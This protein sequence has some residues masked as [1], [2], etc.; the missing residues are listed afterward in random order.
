MNTMAA[1]SFVNGLAT[2]AIMM[3][4][5]PVIASELRE[6]KSP[7]ALLIASDGRPSS[8]FGHSLAV[9]GSTLIAGAPL[10]ETDSDWQRGSAYVFVEV[11]NSWAEQAILIAEDGLPNDLFGWSVAISGKIAAVGAPNSVEY[12]G[13]VYVFERNGGTWTQRAKLVA[14]D[15]RRDQVFGRSVAVSGDTILVGSPYWG[16]GI[17]IEAGAAYVFVREGESWLQQ[18]RLTNP[19]P[20][21]MDWFGWSVALDGD[22]ALIGAP[23]SSA[24]S[25]DRQGAAFVFKRNGQDWIEQAK[26]SAKD[27]VVGEFFGGSVAVSNDAALIGAVYAD[28]EGR[29]RQGAAYLFRNQ[30][31]SW[32][33]PQKLTASDGAASDYFGSSVAMLGDSALVGSPGAD[34][35]GSKGTGSAYVFLSRSDGW[36]EAQTIRAG[37]GTG[38]ALA[39]TEHS[40][41]VGAPY[42]DVGSNVNQGSIHVKSRVSNHLF[43]DGF[44]PNGSGMHRNDSANV[45]A[46][47]R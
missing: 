5:N 35:L 24:G 33:K 34:N 16:G 44:D 37:E 11:E 17:Y 7:P 29:T 15:G 41:L 21:N 9:N 20:Q 3:L 45:A 4:T 31:S 8:Q 38:L 42:D 18:A 47:L 43:S 10:H 26:L 27:S 12:T 32:G 13:A 2:F 39:L 28:V 25:E 6:Q 36:Q 19:V 46:K 30:A 40:A 22:L 14:A 1:A 23:Q